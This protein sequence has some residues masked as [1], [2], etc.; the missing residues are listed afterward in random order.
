M[1][2][3]LKKKVILNGRFVDMQFVFIYKKHEDS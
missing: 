1:N 2:A 3:Y